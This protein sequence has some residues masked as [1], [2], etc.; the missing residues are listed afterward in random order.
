MK[1]YVHVSIQSTSSPLCAL[2]SLLVMSFS[3]RICW[4]ATKFGRR[5]STSTSGLLSWFIAPSAITSGRYL[6][7]RMKLIKNWQL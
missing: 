1:C 4:F 3:R 2:F 7:D 6:M 5:M